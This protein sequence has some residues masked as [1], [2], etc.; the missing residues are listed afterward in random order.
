ML[1]E[2]SERSTIVNL[3]M[4]NG[5]FLICR[6][7]RLDLYILHPTE[8]QPTEPPT[9]CCKVHQNECLKTRRIGRLQIYEC[10]GRKHVECSLTV[11][12]DIP[13]F[14]PATYRNS[15]QPEAC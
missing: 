2:N 13:D 5:S 3:Y 8:H 14:H 15:W 11:S 4:P 12:Y 1:L 6:R 10:R 9:T 7:R